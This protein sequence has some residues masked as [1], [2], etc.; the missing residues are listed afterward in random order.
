[1]NDNSKISVA[2]YLRVS[3]DDQ[4]RDYNYNYNYSNNDENHENNDDFEME[5]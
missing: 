1:M 3:T 5:M 2:I 4:V